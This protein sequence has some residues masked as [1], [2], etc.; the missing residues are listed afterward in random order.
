VLSIDAR[1]AE[2]R[3]LLEPAHE[4]TAERLFERDWALAL[5]ETVLAGLRAEY[6]RSGRG[7]VFEALKGVLTDGARCLSQAELAHRLGTTEAA[8]QVAVHR[9]RKRYRDSLREAIAATVADPAEVEDELR[10]LFAALG[11]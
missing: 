1:D 2:G 7:A 4:Q 10:A 9:L 3:Y 11:Q 6:E 8:V 5:L